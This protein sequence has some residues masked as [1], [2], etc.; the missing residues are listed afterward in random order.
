MSFKLNLSHLVC[1][2]II[3]CIIYFILQYRR[4]KK[5]EEGFTSEIPENTNDRN[6][7]STNQSN[8]TY[9][10]LQVDMNTIEEKDKQESLFKKMNITSIQDLFH[11][12]TNILHL[13]KWTGYWR[14][15]DD[16]TTEISGGIF[17]QDISG[18]DTTNDNILVLRKVQD[19][20]FF[21]LSRREYL[22]NTFNDISNLPYSRYMFV[23]KA[24][25]DSNDSNK[26]NMIEI[27][28][29]TY[30]QS[31]NLTNIDT[32][33]NGYITF[34]PKTTVD[35]TDKISFSFKPNSGSDYQT[36]T[37]F[38]KRNAIPKGVSNNSSTIPYYYDTTATLFSDLQCPPNQDKCS[39]TL[40]GQTTI[41]S[42]CIDKG[43]KNSDN[44]CTIDSVT[45]DVC[46]LDNIDNNPTINYTI[47]GGINK[48]INKC[49][50]N[51]YPLQNNSDY[52]INQ[53]IKGN[54]QC[55]SYLS[56]LTSSTPDTTYLVYYLY[57]TNNI[58]DLGYQVWGFS[59]QD[60]KLITQRT[61]LSNL[62]YQ[63]MINNSVF[64]TFVMNQLN[65]ST[66]N[67]I[68]DFKVITS[69][70]ENMANNI[71]TWQVS[72]LYNNSPSCFFKLSSKSTSKQSNYHVNYDNTKGT[73]GVSV[74]TG[75]NQNAL[76]ISD[77]GIHSSTNM[78][79][80]MGYLRNDLLFIS[81]GNSTEQEL[82]PYTGSQSNV[83]TLT[84]KMNVQGKWLIMKITPPNGQ[85]FL[86]VLKNTSSV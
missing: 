13:D 60:S 68:K 85:T 55:P 41:Y 1:V 30:Y 58:V 80:Y 27:Y 83:C 62:L 15:F 57:D 64:K 79:A 22:Q 21:S 47:N 44:Q 76:M 4:Y 8:S 82:N 25:I 86:D 16:S 24:Q 29:D 75:G 84:S 31:T 77:Q 72:K 38:T 37:S 51:N 59:S 67:E 17:T 48:T 63:Y 9:Y 2:V 45:T 32:N 53:F 42:A 40:N 71:I 19:N 7:Y 70:N 3:L 18:I 5:M 20:I 12:I 39:F 10:P 36:I 6:Y 23:G 74:L 73:V 65:M 49:S 11:S 69:V 46:Y 35:P 56:E 14:N 26:A 52:M 61:V 33:R 81:P 28:Q 54:Q 43:K 50:P 34:I 78:K 66:F